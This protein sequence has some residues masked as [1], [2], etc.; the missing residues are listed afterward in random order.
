MRATCDDPKPSDFIPTRPGVGHDI[1]EPEAFWNKYFSNSPKLAMEFAR[2]ERMK[3]KIHARENEGEAKRR[4]SG[5]PDPGASKVSL[6]TLGR[7]ETSL[8]GTPGRRRLKKRTMSNPVKRPSGRGD[9]GLQ[10]G[11]GVG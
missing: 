8:P 3:R 9:A 1:A 4:K 10:V 11:G 2:K 7:L 6:P 5:H